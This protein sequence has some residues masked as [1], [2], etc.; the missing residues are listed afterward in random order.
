MR[1]ERNLLKILT[2]EECGVAS[3]H[4]FETADSHKK[5]GELAA[6]GGQFGMAVSH[7]ILS[8]EETV[9]AFLLYIQSLNLDLR[10]VPGIHLYFTDHIIRHQFA[11]SVNLMIALLKPFMGLVLKERDKI[12]SP[13]KA[14][15]YT[16]TEQIWLSRDKEKMER[17]FES[18]G[19]VFDWW[20]DANFKKNRGFYVDYTNSIE[21]PMQVSEIEYE[22]AK[23]LISEFQNN[24]AEIVDQLKG[25]TSDQVIEF[26]KLAKQYNSIKTLST[27]IEARRKQLRTKN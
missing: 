19:E 15:E 11:T 24:I 8:S 27:L 18:I 14:I 16:E 17:L 3:Q 10:N 5:V 26:L 2:N 23:R 6:S 4:S 12:H 22:N 21:T 13:E 25:L 7:L 1:K 9:K 20:E